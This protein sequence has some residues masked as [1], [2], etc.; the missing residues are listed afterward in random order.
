MVK[1]RWVV[2][3]YFDIF[4]KN[5]QRAYGI[6]SLKKVREDDLSDSTEKDQ[7]GHEKWAEWKQ[8]K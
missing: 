6:E 7:R 4:L 2:S 1:E 5:K 8:W 3:V